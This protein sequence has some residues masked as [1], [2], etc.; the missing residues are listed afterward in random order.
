MNCPKCSANVSDDALFCSACGYS[1]SEEKE[2]RA[3]ETDNY[4][5]GK[6]MTIPAIKSSDV[7]RTQ[8]ESKNH[9]PQSVRKAQVSKPSAAKKKKT[10]GAVIFV[11]VFLITLV[12]GLSVVLAVVL[13]DRDESKSVT[14]PETYTPVIQEVT[15]APEEEVPEV[16]EEG[17]SE[18][19]EEKSVMQID[20]SFDFAYG[21]EVAFE[22][23]TFKTM[24]SSEY[25]YECAIP[26]EFVFVSEKEGE[27][28]YKAENNT[29]YMDI[30]AVSNTDSYD[31]N[32]LK[33]FICS[34]L[35]TGANQY[36][37][38]DG[39]FELK[40]TKNGNIYFYKCFVDG[41]IR[42]IE[43]A[44]PEEYGD[45]YGEYMIKTAESFVKTN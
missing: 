20:D 29:A 37:E 36:D 27:I 43:F 33:N 35:D 38:Y 32:G 28:R 22:E 42:Y 15:E 45:A 8:N 34:K 16:P 18:G 3:Y 31:M 40:C 41:N 6:T 24:S 30:G 26:Q 19:V 13:M 44:Y 23:Y 14:D 39:Y 1:M 12:I 7:Y 10:G 21:E 4:D 9:S 5:M 2:R 25:G 11:I 17:E